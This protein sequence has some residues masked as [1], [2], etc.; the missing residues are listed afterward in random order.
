MFRR[1]RGLPRPAAAFRAPILAAMES[2]VSD[3]A[4]PNRASLFNLLFL[5]FHHMASST[6]F[7]SREIQQTAGC[8]NCERRRRTKRFDRRRGALHNSVQTHP[9]LAPNA[10]VEKNPM[11][12]CAID[13]VMRTM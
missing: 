5:N 9:A 11:R 12:A 2:M 7:R 10:S 13:A 3:E 6:E 8:P 1:Y 4:S